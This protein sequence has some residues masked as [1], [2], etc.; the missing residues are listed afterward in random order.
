MN[1]RPRVRLR[2]N[3]CILLLLFAA[4]LASCATRR[5]VPVS[6]L[7]YSLPES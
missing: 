1:I 6:S 7:V 4:L 5:T 2:T 3:L